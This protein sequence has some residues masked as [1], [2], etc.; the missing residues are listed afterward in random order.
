MQSIFLEGRKLID[1]GSEFAPIFNNMPSVTG[2]LTWCTG[3]L[4]RI[5]DPLEKLANLG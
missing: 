2:A 1:E 3:L 5:K 4:E